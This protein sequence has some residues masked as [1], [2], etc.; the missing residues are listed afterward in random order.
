MHKSAFNT[1]MKA[2]G[3]WIVTEGSGRSAS[4]HTSQDEAWKETR[5]L[6]RGA[7]SEAILRGKD[8]KVL[9]RNHYGHISTKSKE[10]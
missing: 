9:T 8:G 6:A 2:G 1:V 4:K 10:R 7:G 5:R 3:V